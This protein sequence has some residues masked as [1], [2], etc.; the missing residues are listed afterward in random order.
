[1]RG[2]AM[3][4]TKTPSAPLENVLN[5]EREEIEEIRRRRKTKSANSCNQGDLRKAADE[6]TM[7]I[8]AAAPDR[9]E[10]DADWVEAI[11]KA[12]ASNLVG[13]A[14]SGGGI[15]S[16]TFNLGVLQALA[17]LKLLYRVDYLSTVSGGGYIGSWLAAWTKRTRNFGEVQQMLSTNRV[18]LEDD[19]ESAPIRFLRTYSNYLTPQLGL[20]SGDTLAMVAIYLRNLLLNPAGM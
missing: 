12:H 13:L 16:A 14:F 8:A 20:F 17:D 19:I 4:D 5:A 10:R 15:R 11:K 1:M 3:L 9:G 18:Q 2:K 7:P 6:P